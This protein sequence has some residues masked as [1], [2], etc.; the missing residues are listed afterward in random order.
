MVLGVGCGRESAAGG[1]AISRKPFKYDVGRRL[2][3]GGMGCQHALR[4]LMI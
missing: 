3:S 2:G 1:S 4:K